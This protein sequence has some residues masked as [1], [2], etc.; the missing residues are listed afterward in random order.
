MNHF[1][2]QC[3]L[4]EQEPPSPKLNIP[5]V[6]ID[7]FAIVINMLWSRNDSDIDASAMMM[8]TAAKVTTR[9][10]REGGASNFPHLCAM[11]VCLCLVETAT[12][13]ADCSVCEFSA[14]A[15]LNWPITWEGQYD[16][17]LDR[18]GSFPVFKPI[19]SLHQVSKQ[20]ALINKLVEDNNTL[21]LS[22]SQLKV[23]N[24]V[25]EGFWDTIR[26]NVLEGDFGLSG[27]FKSLSVCQYHDDS[28]QEKPVTR[29]PNN[30]V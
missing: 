11:K 6:W 23:D 25:F 16:M 3:V 1:P 7:W 5:S 4:R 22:N 26:E 10:N 24:E 17:A 18:G 12:L 2:G 20:A 29:Y 14:D 8:M 15:Y 28:E 27:R 21:R 19:I 30:S 9:G 13:T